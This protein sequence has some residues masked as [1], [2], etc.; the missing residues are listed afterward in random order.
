[1][2]FLLQTF[3]I[4]INLLN[5][6]IVIRVVL[7]WMVRDRGPFMNFMIYCTEPILGPIRRSIPIVNGL[8]FSQVVAWFLL[9]LL[10]KFI[11]SFFI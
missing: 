5:T 7:S 6:L 8:D 4:L 10:Q 11:D 9:D 1:M 3:N 2:F